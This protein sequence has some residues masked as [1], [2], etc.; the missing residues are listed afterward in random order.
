[1]FSLHLSRTLVAVAVGAA[2]AGTAIAQPPDTSQTPNNPN[3]NNTNPPDATNP[4][5]T[6]TDANNNPPEIQSEDELTTPLPEIGCS[7]AFNRATMAANKGDLITPRTF[8]GP[9]G[10]TSA[11]AIQRYHEDKVKVIPLEATTAGN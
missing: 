8:R 11:A 4:T 3:P 9:D 5:G 7:N 10:V 2:F 6:N 1:M